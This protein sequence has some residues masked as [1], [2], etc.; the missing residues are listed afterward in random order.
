LA[1]VRRALCKW[2]LKSELPTTLR[3][4]AKSDWIGRMA[5][6]AR[7]FRDLEYVTVWPGPNRD[8]RPLI[9]GTID[10]L[11]RETDGWHL[12]VL[13]DGKTSTTIRASVQAWVVEQQFGERARNVNVVNVESEE[14]TCLVEWFDQA[15]LCRELDAAIAQLR[16]GTP[17]DLGGGPLRTGRSSV[18]I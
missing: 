1:T 11:W 7:L 6:A 18:G 8:T 5:R 4:F 2:D 17:S 12:L 14:L 16:P 13:T 3:R 10:A 15:S 9:R